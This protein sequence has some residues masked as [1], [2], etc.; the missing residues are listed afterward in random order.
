MGRGNVARGASPSLA[1]AVRMIAASEAGRRPAMK[2]PLLHGPWPE[3]VWTIGHSTL[4]AA[5]FAARLQAHR[6]DAIAD[7]RRFPASARHPHFGREDMEGWLADAGID[8]LWL[9][10]LGGRR[11]PRRDSP[12]T[13]WRNESFRGYADHLVSAE[14]AEGMAAL[15]ALARTRRTALMCAEALWWQCHRALV[16]DVLKVH[17]VQVL[18]LGAAEAETSHP[19]TA[20][21]TVAGGEL[22]Y[23]GP[24]RALF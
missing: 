9:P 14:F 8:Y 2:F 13:A 24:Q 16:A 22:S 10:Q 23:G 4:D 21:A 1:S 7:V 6:L 11:R 18:H 19:Y 12:N 15:C 5:A 20:A 17:G 3:T